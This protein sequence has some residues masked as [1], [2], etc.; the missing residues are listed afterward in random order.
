MCHIL[1][2]K[3]LEMRMWTRKCH[4]LAFEVLYIKIKPKVFRGN[5][6]TAPDDYLYHIHIWIASWRA[7]DE[8]A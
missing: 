3:S 7:P 2:R 1:D 5:L 8:S 6:W 4:I